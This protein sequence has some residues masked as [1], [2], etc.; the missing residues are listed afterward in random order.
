MSSA[1]GTDADTVDLV[2]NPLE[3]VDIKNGKEIAWL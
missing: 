3:I 1:E 2:L